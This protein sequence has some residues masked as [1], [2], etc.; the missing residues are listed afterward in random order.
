VRSRRSFYVL[1]GIT[2]FMVIAAMLSQRGAQDSAVS[3]GLHAPD[4]GKEIDKLRSVEIRTASDYLRLEPGETGWL[5]VNREDY[6]ANAERIRQLVLGLSQLRRLEKKTSDPARYPRLE[7]RGVEDPESRA[8][9]FDLLDG[10]D[11]PLAAML[12]GKTRDFQ[13]KGRSRYFVRN[14]GEAQSWLVEGALPPVLDEIRNWLEP[15]LLAGIDQQDFRSITVSHPDG[16]AVAIARP[17]AEADFE[18]SGPVADGQR[19]SQ[20][21][22]NAL[23]DTFRRLTLKNFSGEEAVRRAPPV[24]EVEARTFDGVDV[25]AR[26]KKGEPDFLVQLSASLGSSNGDQAGEARAGDLNARWRGHWFVVSQ[27]DLDALLVKRVDLLEEA[28]TAAPE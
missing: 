21:A 17:D 22:V 28:G 1:A 20:Y 10:D 14:A 9:R 26:I 24:A 5:A 16:D 8:V 19:V 27:Y 12:I 23:A 6:P 25:T 7:L 3:L 15:G 11:R 4:L 13:A 2:L 18:L